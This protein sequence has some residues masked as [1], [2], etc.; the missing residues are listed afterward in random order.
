MSRRWRN[1]QGSIDSACWKGIWGIT[2]HNV[3]RE[4]IKMWQKKK[5]EQ[6]YLY[7]IC[8]GELGFR[9]GSVVKNQPARQEPWVQTLGWEDPLE[10][11][12]ATQSSLLAW[13]IP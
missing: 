2:G 11:E 3:E 7:S 6:N 4:E 5:T 12:M 13:G 8:K 10:K 9:G 1:F